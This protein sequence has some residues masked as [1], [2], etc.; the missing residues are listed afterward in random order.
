MT[1]ISTLKS[2]SLLF[3]LVSLVSCGS[4][5][6]SMN[7]L[8]DITVTPEVIDGEQHISLSSSLEMGNVS[9]PAVTIP[10]LSS[11]KQIGSIEMQTVIGGQNELTVKVNV[12]A[13]ADLRYE[14]ASLP[15]GTTIPLI[16]GNEVI[17]IPVGNKG[18]IYLSLSNGVYALGAAIP[19][20]SLDSLGRSTGGISIFP[21]FNNGEVIASAGMYLSQT[22]G[23]NGLAIVADISSVF[24]GQ[25]DDIGVLR[26]FAA[27]APQREEAVS[28][29]HLQTYRANK[30]NTKR[31]D[32]VMYGLHKKRSTLKLY[33]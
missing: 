25:A 17:V 10:I 27:M 28:S 19:F 1:F 2:F 5:S 22:S 4:S 21:I 33:K 24:N 12:S 32:N 7:I 20:S 9:L 8:K 13:V 26:E 15:N 18:E 30:T 14:R 6:S 3:A 11:G 29:L 16:G 23:Q 31:V